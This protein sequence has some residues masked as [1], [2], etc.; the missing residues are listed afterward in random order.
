MHHANACEVCQGSVLIPL[1]YIEVM[2]DN[3]VDMT[4]KW[5]LRGRKRVETPEYCMRSVVP[6]GVVRPGT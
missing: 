3:K 2:K 6:S 4:G 5:Y 1:S